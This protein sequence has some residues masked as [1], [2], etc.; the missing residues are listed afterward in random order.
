MLPVLFDEFVA[1]MALSY[2]KKHGSHSFLADA[3]QYHH[4][5]VENILDAHPLVKIINIAN[6]LSTASFN[7]EDKYVFDAAEELLG[8]SDHDGVR[9]TS[10]S[11][12]T[13]DLEV[14]FEERHD[15]EKVITLVAV[16]EVPTETHRFDLFHDYRF[17]RLPRFG[18]G[19]IFD[20]S[21]PKGLAW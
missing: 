4:E 19:S 2:L 15:R 20:F 7:D 8:L 18:R 21:R 12:R 11:D 9:V 17:S 1:F 5:P 10:E 6:Q 3:I 14:I 13:G 16:D